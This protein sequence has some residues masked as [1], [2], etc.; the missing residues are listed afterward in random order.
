M[1]AVVV[2]NWEQYPRPF[3]RFVNDPM[4]YKHFMIWSKFRWEFTTWTSS[5]SEPRPCLYELLSMCG[6]KISSNTFLHS[7]AYKRLIHVTSLTRDCLITIFLAYKLGGTFNFN[8]RMFGVATGSILQRK[9]E[10]AACNLGCTC[11]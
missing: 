1:P 3:F 8:W 7:D 6:F 11:I 5:Q 4:V 2:W 9:T 10:S